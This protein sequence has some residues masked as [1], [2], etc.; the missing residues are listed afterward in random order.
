MKLYMAVTAD[1]YE[2]PVFVTQTVTEMAKWY[3]VGP[4]TIYSALYRYDHSTGRKR[5]FNP[6]CTVRFCRVE[7]EEEPEDDE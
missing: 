2:L 1:D 4:D 7:V 6:A 5:Q 3:G